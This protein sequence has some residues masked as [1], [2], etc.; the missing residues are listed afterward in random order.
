MSGGPLRHEA[1]DGLW[2]TGD[3]RGAIAT[4]LSEGPGK[5][6]FSGR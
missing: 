1:Q 5:A 4:F 3:V 6:E 2:D